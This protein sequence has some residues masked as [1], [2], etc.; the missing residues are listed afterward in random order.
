MLLNPGEIKLDEAISL[1]KEV[2]NKGRELNLNPLTATVIDIA[3]VVRAS[4]SEEGS[5][6][7]RSDIAYAKAWTCLAFGVS[8]NK[9]RDIFE[10][11]P[12]LSPAVRGMQ[13]LADGKLIPTPGGLLIQKDGKNIGAIG[14]TGDTSDQDELCAITAIEKLGFSVGHI[15]KID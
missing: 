5:G 8:S 11:Q 7:I 12:R 6:L 13:G 3:G 10:A 15:Q 9:L 14:V 4:L 2:L 1:C